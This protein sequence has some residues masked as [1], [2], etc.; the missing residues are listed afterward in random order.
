MRPVRIP[1]EITK[2]LSL[3]LRME[4]LIQNVNKNKYKLFLR[5]H[6]GWNTHSLRYAFI[7]HAIE[8]NYPPELV[9]ILVG[10]KRI[11]TTVD[12]AR[13]INSEKILNDIQNS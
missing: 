2:Y 13:K 8:K 9:S 10:H 11:N 5:K 1:S 3:Y 12:Y 7:R 4:G 6:F